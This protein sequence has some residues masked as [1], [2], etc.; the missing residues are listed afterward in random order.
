MCGRDNVIEGDRERERERIS[1]ENKN[2]DFKALTLFL[3]VFRHKIYTFHV[4]NPENCR[5]N[6]PMKKRERKGERRG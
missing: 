4:H 5:Q 3:D 2:K 6:R 1:Y